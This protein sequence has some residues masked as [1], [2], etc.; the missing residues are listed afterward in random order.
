[1]NLVNTVLCRVQGAGIPHLLLDQFALRLS[2]PAYVDVFAR[3]VAA[4]SSTDRSTE[5]WAKLRARKARSYALIERLKQARDLDEAKS[6]ARADPEG[7][8]AALIDV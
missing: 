6:L 1:M 4:H 8:C 7:A 3:A 5:R 2:E